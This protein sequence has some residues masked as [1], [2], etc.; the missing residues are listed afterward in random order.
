MKKY[1]KT[2]WNVQGNVS[3]LSDAFSFFSPYLHTLDRHVKGKA[4]VLDVGCGTGKY[5]AYLASKGCEVIGVDVSKNAVELARKYHP[6]QRFEVAFAELLPFKNESFDAVYCFD[7][8]EHVNDPVVALKEMRR[9]L[10]KDG[11]LLFEYETADRS[12]H[13]ARLNSLNNKT[14]SN[15]TAGEAMLRHCAK[16]FHITD[17][18]YF[19]FFRRFSYLEDLFPLLSRIPGM[20]FLIRAFESVFAYLFKDARGPALFVV[21]KKIDF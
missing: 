12:G 19:G 17:Y 21:C 11:T 9:V 15:W 13:K 6:K 2:V 18:F 4:K 16:L 7:V 10:K 1:E 8:L 5:A 3:G 20:N 14:L